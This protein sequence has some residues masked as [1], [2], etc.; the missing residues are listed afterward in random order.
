MLSTFWVVFDTSQLADYYKDVH[1]LLALPK[2]ATMRYDYKEKY[3]SA[4]AREHVQCRDVLPI[5]LVYTQKNAPYTRDEKF[6]H[7]PQGN[8]ALLYFGTRLATMLNITQDAQSYYFDF[9]VGAYPNQ[10]QEA[11]RDILQRLASDGETPWSEVKD[12]R[13]AGKYVCMSSA[14]D[15]FKRLEAGED[16]ANWAAIVNALGKPPMQFSDDAFWRLKGPYS[17]GVEAIQEPAIEYH[18]PSGKTRQA[19]AVY[20]ITENTALRVELVS[21]ISQETGARPPFQVAGASSDDKTLQFIGNPVFPLRR[22][23]GLIIN[24]RAKAAALIG[25]TAA[26]LSFT[27]SPQ[28]T[29]WVSGPQLTFKYRV[30]RNGLRMLAGT[31]AGLLGIASYVVGNSKVLDGYPWWA[32]V[33]QAAGILLG[34]VSVFSLTGK[35]GFQSK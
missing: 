3:L 5:L 25:P 8:H 20:E 34:A 14:L 12:N 4:A 28:R 9:Q 11:L 15:S 33:L 24:Y 17:S 23:T 19:E 10:D 26:D 22:Y 30:K 21:D 16:Q 27:T 31:I 2:G 18:A 6:S 7:A 1:N 29:P 35:I 32:V 13:P